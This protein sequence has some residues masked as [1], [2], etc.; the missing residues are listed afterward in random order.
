M[1]VLKFGSFI[2]Q[3]RKSLNLTQSQ[4]AAKIQVTDKAVSRWERGLGFPDI[5]TIEPLANALELSIVEL[6]KSEKIHQ[7]DISVENAAAVVADSLEIAA[8]QQLKEQKN[9]WRIISTAA[10]LSS[11]LQWFEQMDWHPADLQLQARIPWG[12]CVL[13]LLL[14]IGGIVRRFQRKPCAQMIAAAFIVLL[15]PFV[16]FELTFLILALSA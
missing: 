10:I 3:R 6:M 2:A 12:V 9:I 5:N 15:L 16:L 1:D 13:F 14:L 8:E 11:I 7:T 4:L